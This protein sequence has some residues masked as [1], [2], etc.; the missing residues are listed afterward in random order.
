MKPEKAKIAIFTILMLLVANPLWA[1]KAHHS[2]YIGF[3][4]MGGG[5]SKDGGFIDI[6]GVSCGIHR[7][8]PFGIEAALVRILNYPE[9]ECM[10]FSLLPF[11][12][13]LPML[14]VGWMGDPDIVSL[15][16]LTAR[17]YLLN[18][19]IYNMKVFPPFF[20]VGIEWRSYFHTLTAGYRHQIRSLR[21]EKESL[22][23]SGFF[24]SA[25]V[26]AGWVIG[27]VSRR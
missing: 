9:Q 13:Y 20:D 7:P 10:T 16:N 3:A 5:F 6:E 1:K 18:G 22:N 14:T 24:V 8:R 21:N 19:E 11:G 25:Q 27:E 23:I 12:I 2:W 17:I 15:M 26:V 4:E